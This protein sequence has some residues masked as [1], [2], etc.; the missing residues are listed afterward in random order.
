VE[1]VEKL[2]SEQ[3]H[4]MKDMTLEQLDELWEVVKA[5]PTH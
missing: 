3:G 2:A 1:S 4:V 5:Y